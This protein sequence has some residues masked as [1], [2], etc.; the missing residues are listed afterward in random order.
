MTAHSFDADARTLLDL[1]GL[2][3][4]EFPGDNLLALAEEDP[5]DVGEIARF[6]I[7]GNALSASVRRGDW[8]RPPGGRRAIESRGSRGCEDR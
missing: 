4:V 8:P 6:A 1:S 7:A 3:G 2:G 5:R